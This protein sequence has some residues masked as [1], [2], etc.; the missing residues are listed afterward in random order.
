MRRV[1]LTLFVLLLAVA[2]GGLWYASK[3]GFTGKWRGYVREEFHK[4]GVE[5]TLRRLTL[6][7][8]RGLVAKEVRI[9]DARDKKRVLAEIDEMVLQIN[10]ANL[11]RGKTFLDALD[12]R[13]ANISLPVDPQKPHGHKIE[14]AHLNGRLFLPPQQIY[15]AYADAE[16]FGLHVSA[17]GRLIHPQAF[18]LSSNSR[19]AA[20]SEWITR[21]FEELSAIKFES[22]PPVVSLT[23]SGDLAQPDQIFVDLALWAE[24]IRRHK[25]LLKNLYIGASWRGGTL[26]LKQFVATDAAGE[27]RL[28][29][30][31]ERE[32]QR[33]QLQLRSGIDAA[34]FAR[35]CGNFPWLEDFVFYAPPAIDL[36]LDATLGNKIE[37]LIS[38]QFTAK[39]FAYRSIVF[40]HA[41]TGFSWDGAQWSLRDALLARAN[42]EE[43]RGDA[44]QV[45]GDFR[46]RLDSTM[47]P[48]VF[49]PLL[50]DKLAETLRQLELPK[51]PHVTAEARGAT[52]DFDAVRVDGE[53]VVG[54]ASFRGV[55]AENARATMHYEDHVL[56]VAPFFLKRSEGDASGN[57]YFDLRRDEVRLSKVKT[58]VNP[59]E[60]AMWIDPKL[61]NDI[62]PYRFPRQP[63]NLLIEGL[64]STKNSRATRLTIQV[65]APAGM[66]YTFLK[67]NLSSPQLN[68]KL[69][70]ANDRLKVTDFSASLLGGTIT[71]GADISLNRSRPGYSASVALGNV[72]FTSLTKLYF[73]YDN[74]QGRLNGRYDFTGS[75]SDD[76]RNVEGHGELSV[77]EGNVFAIPFLG[78]FSGIL[79]GIVPGLGRDVAHK[80]GASFT[81]DHGVITTDNFAVQGKGFN[82]L[83]NGKLYFLDDKMDFNMR[84]NAQGISG[85][86]L[87]PVSKLF[88]YTADQKLSKP[89]WRMRIIPRL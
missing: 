14:I 74:S 68:G 5:V 56:S 76:G 84:I 51:A 70:F 39:K 29:G 78:P 48:I 89:Q 52:A 30:L 42:G 41:E 35:T 49:R 38:G 26:D 21:F 80:A 25:Y 28:T 24:R 16:V 45:A 66:D 63:P 8:L 2:L 40:E 36:R 85:V 33:A 11:I 37:F 55:P 34:A 62:L 4:R 61:V 15:L 7:P 82:M 73:D 17:S 27:L 71:G 23:F 54:P 47:N 44:M 64:V 32:S 65:D 77:T 59:P 1:L 57:L 88:E 87:F 50:A 19:S 72:D 86:L 12:L 60:A 20:A 53:V 9:F 81:I 6:D 83:G 10:Y 31:W 75:G 43:I 46:A 3:K 67:K 69:L 18:Q 22:G 58:R 13:D 79:D